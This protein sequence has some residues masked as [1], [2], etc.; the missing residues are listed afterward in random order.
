[1]PTTRTMSHLAWIFAAWIF[2]ACAILP[3]QDTKT[4]TVEIRDGRTA[5]LITPS[6][7]LMRVDHSDALH[8][9]WVKMNDDGTITATFP[10][11]VK[12]I[13]FQA[14]Y[15]EGMSTYINCDV[16]KQGDKERQVW[17]PVDRVVSSGVVTP[18]ECS[19]TTLKEKPGKFVLFV[20]KRTVFD[21]LHNADTQ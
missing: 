3:A 16:S 13:S 18:N 19:R 15:D 14:T 6:N 21:R 1:M 17:Y 5:A 20:R 2:A 12:E 8:I 10:G 9:E 4:I 7:L 11:D